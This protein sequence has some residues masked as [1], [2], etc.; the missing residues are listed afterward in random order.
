M[1]KTIKLNE[2]QLRRIVSESV[3]RILRED[4]ECEKWDDDYVWEIA[5][6]IEAEDVKNGVM[7]DTNYGDIPFKINDERTDLRMFF[8]NA[9]E[10]RG[11]CNSMSRATDYDFF[12]IPNQE[13][14][15]LVRIPE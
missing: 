7:I 6:W 15:V 5:D 3:K 2:S 1:K 9:D 8:D 10:A 4:F 14:I 11:F 13:N 12:V